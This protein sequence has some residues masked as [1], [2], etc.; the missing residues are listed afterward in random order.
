MDT[1]NRYT[2]RHTVNTGQNSIIQRSVDS[3]T[4]QVVALKII[5]VDFVKP[6]HSIKN[7]IRIL[8]KLNND[9]FL[10][11]ITHHK[12]Y[13]DMII[14]TEYYEQGDLTQLM[15][16]YQTKRTKFNL[17]DPG[18]HKVVKKNNL[19]IDLADAIVLKLIEGLSF[20]HGQGIIHRDIKPLNIFFKNDNPII[21]DFGISYDT[22]FDN[23]E[24]ANNKILDV[25][26]GCYKAPELI[27]GV[28]DYGCAIDLWSMGVLI[29]MLYSIHGDNVLEPNDPQVNDIYLIS[30]I[31]KKF[32]TPVITH[33]CSDPRLYWPQMASD[34]YHF[35]KFE[36]DLFPRQPTNL[37]LPRCTNPG[38]L[39]LFDRMMV[40]DPGARTLN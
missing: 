7:E 8:Q 26:T 9:S 20:L 12:Q 6:P 16:K 1:L 4:S 14:V 37:L 40:Y 29:S 38:V 3:H 25:S 27:F 21:A 5:D 30:L 23:E 2:D 13:D 33:P 24:P 35:N 19:P 11:Y 36:F 31:F 34:K 15:E 22:T 32:G 10:K 18:D 28:T 17:N 39:D